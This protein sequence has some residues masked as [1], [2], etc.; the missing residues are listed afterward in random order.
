[1]SGTAAIRVTSGIGPRGARN[2]IRHGERSRRDDPERASGD[3]QMLPT[4]PAATSS[5]CAMIRTCTNHPAATGWARGR[6]RRRPRTC[7]RM[8][9]ATLRRAFRARRDEQPPARDERSPRASERVGPADPKK[10]RVLVRV[11]SPPQGGG[12]R[13]RAARKVPDGPAGGRCTRESPGREQ[14]FYGLPIPWIGLVSASRSVEPRTRGTLENTRPRGRSTAVREVPF[15]AGWGP[16]PGP[17]PL[18]PRGE[19]RVIPNPTNESVTSKEAPRRT[20]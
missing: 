6:A 5:T 18:V 1:M 19:G 2:L 12:R 16:S 13:G 20:C 10:E 11:D 17:S 15:C 7:V 8:H 4:A 9:D 3:G 14:G